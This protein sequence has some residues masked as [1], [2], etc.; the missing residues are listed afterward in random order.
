M[1]PRYSL[2]PD[3]VLLSQRPTSVRGPEHTLQCQDT[4]STREVEGRVLEGTAVEARG[5]SG[6]GK[7]GRAKS[8]RGTSVRGK[9]GRA[10]SGRANSLGYRFW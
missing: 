8:G 9:S 6:R 10:K 1:R 4:D 7:S 5:K 2:V 3:L